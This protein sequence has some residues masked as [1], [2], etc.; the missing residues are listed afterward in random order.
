MNYLF[1]YFQRTARTEMTARYRPTARRPTEFLVSGRPEDMVNA[2]LPW[3]KE[4]K[5]HLTNFVSSSH[6]ASDG[7]YMIR[8]IAGKRPDRISV[9]RLR[10]RTNNIPRSRVEV[11]E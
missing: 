3:E 1:L 9:G 5:A 11:P 10:V 2:I 7:F 8:R 4:Y 6:F